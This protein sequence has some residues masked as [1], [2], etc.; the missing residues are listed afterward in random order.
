MKIRNPR[1]IAA[2]GWLGTRVARGLIR[3][4][5]VRHHCLGADVARGRLQHAD[6]FIYCIWH[7]NLLL[8]AVHFGGPDLAVLISQHADGKLLGALIAA[9]RMTAVEGSTTRGG[10]DAVRQMVRPDI[11]WR[12]LAITPDG[13]RGPRRVVQHGIIYVASRTGMKIVPVGVG[14][15]RP[16]RM[17]SWDRFAVPKPSSRARMILSE[18][19]TVPNGLKSSGLEP[20][21]LQVQNEMDRLNPLAESWAKTGRL[22]LPTSQAHSVRLAG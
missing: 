2:A 6:R 18:P 4:L 19:I 15:H 7:E 10:A 20:F 8:P 13:P 17:N 3:T 16:W 11:T 14:Y 9:L 1:L 22:A 5:E 12:N 21:R